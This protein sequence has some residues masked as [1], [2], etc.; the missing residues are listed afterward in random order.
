MFGSLVCLTRDK[1]VNLLFAKI[2]KRDADMIKKG[3]LVIGFDDHNNT[4]LNDYIIF[5]NSRVHQP[6]YMV[7]DNVYL[8][9]WRVIRDLNGSQVTAFKAALSQEISVIQGPP[10]TGKTFLGLKIA[11]TLLRNKEAWFNHTPM[12]VICYTNHAL[13]QFLEGD[14]QQLRPTTA[15]YKV[16]T[17]Y[18]MGV[19][20]FERLVR[21]DV[22]CHTLNVQHRMR[23]EICSLIRPA[24]YAKLEDHEKKNS[25][26]LRDVRISVLDNYQGEESDIILL[27]LV[28][29]NAEMKNG[30]LKN[31][32]RVC[33]AL[34]RARN[35]L[36]IMGN[37]QQLCN[38]RESI[39]H[40]IKEK[41]VEQGALGETLELRCQIHDVITKVKKDEDFNKSPEGGCLR[42]CNA[43]LPN[44]SHFCKIICHLENRGHEGYKCMEACGRSLCTRKPEKHICT[45]RVRGG[46]STKDH[47]CRKFCYEECEP[48]TEQ[49]MKHR[50]ICTHVFKVACSSNVDTLICE[51]PCNRTLPCGHQCRKKCC[52]ACGP[53][54]VKVEKVIASCGHK[55]TVRCCQVPSRQDCREKC[56]RMLACGHACVDLCKMACTEK[57]EEMVA[58]QR[59]SPCG[60]VIERIKCF[61]QGLPLDVQVLLKYC[62]VP[63]LVTLQCEHKCGGTCG[64]C[65]QGRVH[66][67]CQERCGVPMVCNHECPIPCR[68]ACRPCEKK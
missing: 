30:F 51:K 12:L 66:A 45:L 57:C 22:Q 29:N 39:W 50:T 42:P 11:D 15:D 21:N 25:L 16:E 64:Q 23:S 52:D 68:E 3:E 17:H 59:N 44:C 32:N 37:I 9:D 54:E 20:L 67:R 5:G 7:G 62:S 56:Q 26:V 33:V 13:D 61:E 18:Q 41:L 63:C 1:F 53:C 35:G 43:S 40:Q 24:I 10:G 31:T 14:H 28:R 55:V 36:Y 48:C 46:C 6:E 47:S 8:R 60:H 65:F 4:D 38:D 27:S 2:V 34:S 19:S 49:V 58:C